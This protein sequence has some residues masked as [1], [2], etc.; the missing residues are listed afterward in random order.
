MLARCF[1]QNFETSRTFAN[2]HIFQRHTRAHDLAMENQQTYDPPKCKGGCGFFGNP[3]NEDLCSKCAKERG[4][5][6]AQQQPLLSAPSPTPAL[7]VAPS[8]SPRPASTIDLEAA[9]APGPA[10]AKKE[11]P[12]CSTCRAKVGLAT[13]FECRC[14]G[15]YCSNHRHADSHDCQFDYKQHGREVLAKANPTIVADK[16]HNK[17]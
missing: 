6:A 7:A 3:A 8:P 4:V 2:Q 17:L 5:A 14:G 1:T 11:K 9:E 13:G 15:L 16:I 10:Q 12:R